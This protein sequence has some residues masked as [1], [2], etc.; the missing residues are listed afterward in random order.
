MNQSFSR[1]SSFRQK[2]AVLAENHCEREPAKN[3]NAA[4]LV[5]H[6]NK[7]DK[8]SLESVHKAFGAAMA[9]IKAKA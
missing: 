6:V 3:A 1:S 8:Y 2:P 5:K 9:K 7:S 4:C